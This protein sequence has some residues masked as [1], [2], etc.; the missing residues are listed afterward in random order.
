VRIEVNGWILQLLDRDAYNVWD[1]E[2]ELPEFASGD[3]LVFKVYDEDVGKHDDLL[4]T[5]TL[6]SE[7]FH[8][9]GFEGALP[10]QDA[11]KGITANLWLRIPPAT[12]VN[13]FAA[14]Q[15]PAEDHA[16]AEVREQ[17]GALTEAV[18]NEFNGL[19]ESFEVISSRMQGAEM[20]LGGPDAVQLAAA[21]EKEMASR[22]ESEALLQH[23]LA[24][25]VDR[26]EQLSQRGPVDGD[27]LRPEHPALQ[28]ALSKVEQSLL[29]SANLQD[30]VQE[31]R[32][33]FLKLAEQQMSLQGG[34]EGLE[35]LRTKVDR[36]QAELVSSL[37]EY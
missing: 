36:L 4:G 3:I 37:E 25:V 29:A 33:E 22:I 6:T 30:G 5:L 27:G 19:H 26:V 13:P 32:Q 17:L 1:Y 7:Q 23:E 11:G 10:L 2:A 18:R 16:V 34:M 31:M 8:P 9:H 15:P 12:V 28:V 24:N 21:L 14:A 20:G 35:D